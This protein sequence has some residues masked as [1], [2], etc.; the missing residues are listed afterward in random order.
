MELFLFLV[1]LL[2]SFTGAVSGGRAGE[3]RGME[4]AAS[5]ATIVETAAEAVSAVQAV[6][7]PAGEVSH[8][9]ARASGRPFAISAPV[10][11][12]VLLFSER[13]QE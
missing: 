7:L 4:R 10:L 9:A 8:V 5:V 13:W 3:M 2:T 1:A 6:A 12:Q 11:R